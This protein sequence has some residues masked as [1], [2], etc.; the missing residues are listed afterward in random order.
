VKLAALQRSTQIKDQF[1]IQQD[2]AQHAVQ[3]VFAPAD[4]AGPLSLVSG[5]A[6]MV[7]H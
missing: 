2:K 7:W 4:H 1:A 5:F 3:G 6:V